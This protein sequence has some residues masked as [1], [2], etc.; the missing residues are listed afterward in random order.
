MGL[1][2][3][4]FSRRAEAAGKHE[5]TLL[6]ADT[7]MKHMSP[8]PVPVPRAAQEVA[9]FTL[10][11]DVLQNKPPF[12]GRNDAEVVA[13]LLGEAPSL[14]VTEQQIADLR[15]GEGELPEDNRLGKAMDDLIKKHRDAANAPDRGG[16]G[17][18]VH[19]E[20]PTVCAQGKEAEP[21]IIVSG[22][23]QFQGVM[24][25]Q[26]NRFDLRSVGNERLAMRINEHIADEARQVT[27]DQVKTWKKK[28][29]ALPH[30]EVV[31]AMVKA[32]RI[33]PGPAGRL[34][35][36]WNR[37]PRLPDGAKR[38]DHGSR[39]GHANA[40]HARRAEGYEAR[41]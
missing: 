15:K 19:K 7:A 12:A 29:G 5:A 37:D 18:E 38:F 6:A 2:W 23:T 4:A 32:L 17:Q 1:E 26:L 41:R 25:G 8:V 3:L 27:E 28:Q 40:V 39:Q 33:E 9:F 21:E 24:A 10:I 14:K 13:L 34:K 36:L 11:A 31:E 16:H 35:Q 20:T 22:P 30:R